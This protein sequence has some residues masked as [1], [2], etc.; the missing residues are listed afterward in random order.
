MQT[1]FYCRK[2]KPFWS[3]DAQKCVIYRIEDIQDSEIYTA[4]TD[5]N[6][7]FESFGT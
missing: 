3:Q 5:Q 7:V 1:W 4:Q 6:K 2:E